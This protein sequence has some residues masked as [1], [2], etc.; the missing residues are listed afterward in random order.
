MLELGIGLKIGLGLE[1]RFRLVLGL[2]QIQVESGYLLTIVT[3]PYRSEIK[4][5]M[6]L[7]FVNVFKANNILITNG[8]RQYNPLGPYLFLLSVE[9][10]V[11]MIR[12]AGADFG[13]ILMI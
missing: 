7:I 10:E 5:D 11:F 4:S 2:E 6:Q 1:L 9:P 12:S 13:R 8:V 3:D